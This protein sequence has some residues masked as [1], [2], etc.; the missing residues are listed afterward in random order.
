MS[1]IIWKNL[2]K[3]R[4]LFTKRNTVM[5]ALDTK[6]AIQ[7]YSANTKIQVTQYTLFNDSVYFR[8]KPAEDKDLNWAIK[9][10]SFDLPKDYLASLVPD[11]SPAKKASPKP[12]ANNLE[13]K[14]VSKRV[15]SPKNEGTAQAQKTSLI[16]RLFRRFKKGE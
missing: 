11:K 6:K 14:K 3:V 16:K 1:K 5:V 2:P 12:S 13:N 10:D 9:A 8:T 15:A 4:G 7:F